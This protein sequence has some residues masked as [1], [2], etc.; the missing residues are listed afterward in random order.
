MIG[1]AV[2][3][4][5]YKIPV[6]SFSRFGCSTLVVLSSASLMDSFKSPIRHF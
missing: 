3:E 2:L 6:K 1:T 4:I 5:F